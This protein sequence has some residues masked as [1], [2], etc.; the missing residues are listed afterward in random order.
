MKYARE[1]FDVTVENQL[2]RIFLTKMTDEIV[3]QINKEISGEN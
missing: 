1:R 3:S 2:R